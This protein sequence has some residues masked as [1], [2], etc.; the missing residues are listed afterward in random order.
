MCDCTLNAVDGEHRQVLILLFTTVP[1]LLPFHSLKNAEWR[2][3]ANQYSQLAQVV[4][5]GLQA[6]LRLD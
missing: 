4:E 5:L 1:V 6:P 3:V 2:K